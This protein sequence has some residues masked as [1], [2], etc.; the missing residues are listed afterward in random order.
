MVPL[1]KVTNV[2]GHF[3]QAELETS[4]PNG[5]PMTNETCASR[6]MVTNCNQQI[7]E[8][9]AEVHSCPDFVEWQWPFTMYYM[10]AIVVNEATST[11]VDHGQ[12][13]GNYLF[14]KVSK[15]K[16][17]TVQYVDYHRAD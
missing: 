11:A 13:D 6:L 15:N 14:H 3:H 12:L 2:G 16:I 8:A 17:T 10:P 1:S 9:E 4:R 7:V 5:N